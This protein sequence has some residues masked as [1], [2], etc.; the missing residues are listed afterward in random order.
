MVSLTPDLL[1]AVMKPA[2][3]TGHEWN[4]SVKRHEDVACTFAL[5]MPDVYEVGMSNLGLKILYEV[6]NRR[7]DTSAERVYAPW[8][9]MEEEMRR[10][11]LPLFSLETRT[12]VRDFDFL[13][14]SL[15]Y[16][17]IYTNVLNMLDLAG[18]P[19]W[20]EERGEDF[21]FV[22]G[23]GPCV[24][25]VE[26]VADFF[27]LFVIGEGEAV[28]GELVS[29]FIAWKHEGKPD[30]RNGFLRRAA[31]ISGIYVPSLYVPRY[32]ENGDFCG[33]ERLDETAP[34]VVYKRVVKDMDAAETMEKPIVPYI[35]IVHDRVMLELFRGC[36]RGCRFCQAGMAYR[37]VRERSREKLRALARKMVDATGYDE[38]SLTSLSSADYSCLD[39]LVDGLMEDFAREKVSFSLPSLRIDSFSIGLA[40]RMQQVRKSGLTFAPEAGTQRMRDVINKGVTEENLLDAVSAA[41]R[42]GWK[43]VKLYFMLGLPTETD[44]DVIGIAKLAKEVVDCYQ[45]VTGKRGAKVTI[46]V[47]CFVPKAFTPFQW[48]AQDSLA[49]FERKQHLLKAHIHDRAIQFNYHD[50]RVS[51]LEGVLARGD[52]RLSR[53]IH[54]AWRRGARFD[55][56]TDQFHE[57]Y[58][59][60]AFAALGVDADYYNGRKRAQDEPFPWEH[61]SPGVARAFLWTE[62]ERGMRGELTPDCRRGHCTGCSVCSTLDVSVVD[63]GQNHER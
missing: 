53:V 35:G 49:E 15:Q 51:W 29:L 34:S 38:M 31:G 47:S 63:G 27:D 37:P 54:E 59:L 22:V 24:Y 16:E 43:S 9:D 8:I 32:D 17:M 1:Q 25:N 26:P 56:W 44:E 20:A 28:L 5:S 13:G 45:R 41:F 23:G 58:W 42:K 57:A 4:C 14:F 48:E 7:Q 11:G 40:D 10:R 21:P 50:A 36:S 3:Y 55:G 6:L 18:I 39:G 19:V 33:M 62:R 12:P 60:D 52:R 2:R 61:T 46:S 30:G